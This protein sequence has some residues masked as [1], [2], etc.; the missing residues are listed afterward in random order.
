MAE[1]ARRREFRF[2]SKAFDRRKAHLGSKFSKHTFDTFI[3]WMN[4]HATARAL[5]A[6]PFESPDYKKRDPRYRKADAALIYLLQLDYPAFIAAHAG[7]SKAWAQKMESKILAQIE[8]LYDPRTGGIRRYLL[9][10]YQRSGFFRHS[11]VQGLAE[12]YGSPSGDASSQMVGR[13]QIVP[14]G[15]EAAWVH[16]VWQLSAWAGRAYL[17]KQSA[18]YRKMHEFYFR[19]GLRLVTGKNEASVDQ[20]TTGASRVIRIE[21]GLMPEC[22]ISDV[23]VDGEE[24]VFP[25]PHTPLNWAV[26]EM[27]DA[28]AV[29]ERVLEALSRS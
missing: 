24:L 26:G 3:E 16:F 2:L 21:A 18:H 11:T 29:R 4:K 17:A 28:F 9:D 25:S 27:R 19:E 12:M 1:F 15:R 23:G 14:K 6:L 7:K 20:D 8:S 22:Y 13:D 5:E 10:S